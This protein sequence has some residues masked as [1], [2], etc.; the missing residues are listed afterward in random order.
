MI[1]VIDQFVNK[2]TDFS[3]QYGNSG[4]I[5]YVADNLIGGITLYPDYGD[6]SGSYNM[7]SNFKI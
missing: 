6:F 5:S 3:S 4:S 1:C 2:I 7:V